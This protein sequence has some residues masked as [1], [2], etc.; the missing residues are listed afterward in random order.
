MGA[1]AENGKASQADL[2]L[3]QEIDTLYA[4]SQRS[5]EQDLFDFKIQK[6]D[7]LLAHKNLTTEQEKM[8]VEARANYEELIEAKTAQDIKN[9]FKQAIDGTVGTYAQGIAEMLIQ[10]K[11]FHKTMGDFLKDILTQIATIIIKMAII[12]GIKSIFGLG[13][14]ASG[15]TVKA[16]DMVYAQTGFQAKGTDTVPAMLTPGEEVLPVPVAQSAKQEFRE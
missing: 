1:V 10:G 6:I 7:E 14:L 8:L 15:G 5:I 3:K 2:K 13:F 4:D 11:A 12:K 9:Q 16:N